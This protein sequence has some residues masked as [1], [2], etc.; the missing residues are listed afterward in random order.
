MVDAG[1]TRCPTRR[2]DPTVEQYRA[3]AAFT[4]KGQ[5]PRATEALQGRAA[6]GSDQ[7]VARSH[8]G[9]FSGDDDVAG[10]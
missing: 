9:F 2:R 10:G 4:A 5:N 6:T 1:R 3:V 7:V 8:P